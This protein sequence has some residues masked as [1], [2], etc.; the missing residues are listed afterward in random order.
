MKCARWQPG[1]P[2]QIAAFAYAD[3]DFPLR[4][5]AWIERSGAHACDAWVAAVAPDG[6]LDWLRQELDL[7][8]MQLHRA[9]TQSCASGL[10]IAYVDPDQ[11]GVDRWLAML[12]ARARD[13]N[14][15]LVA[16][17]GTALTID[18]VTAA[19]EHLGGV[20]TASPT[21][22]RT[23]LVAHAPKLQVASGEVSRFCATTEDA[24]TSGGVLAAA[25]LIERSLQ[26]LAQR[27]DTAP[28]LWLT[29]GG[30]AA[31]VPWL[32]EHELVPELVLEGLQHWAQTRRMQEVSS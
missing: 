28:R 30:A 9:T 13:A 14:P 26:E 1:S 17:V 21:I 27:V 18:A 22:M 10:R 11:L 3:E 19:G 24:V 15:F 8:Q 29:G 4:V 20:I 6:R 5:R 12:A 16:S 2:L 32:P 7:H 25:A 23:A 31:L